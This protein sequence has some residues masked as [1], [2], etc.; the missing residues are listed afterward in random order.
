MA[1]FLTIIFILVLGILALVGFI[2]VGSL[3]SKGSVERALNMTL[4]SITLPR[5][6]ETPQGTQQRPEKELI[7]IMEQLFSSLSN[8]HSKGWNKFVY[9]EPYISFEISV[10]N[11]GEEIIFYAAVPKYFEETFQK[12]VYGIFPLA[13]VV[14]VKDYNIFNSN[15]TS[16][17]AYLK[18][19]ANPI[20]PIKTYQMLEIDP[21]NNILNALSKLSENGEGAAIQIL[22]RPSHQD[23]IKKLAQRVSKEM[24]SGLNFSKALQA[25]KHP[26]KDKKPDDKP[27]PPRI[28]TPFETEIVKGIQSK[29]SKSLFD[30]NLRIIASAEDSMRAQQILDDICGSFVQLSSPD[31]N[32]FKV[33]KSAGRYIEKLLFNFSFRIFNNKESILL[34]SEEITSLYHFPLP[35]TLAPRVRFLRSKSAEPPLELPKEGISIGESIYR[36]EERIIRLP[37][38]DRRRHLYIIGQTGTGKTT[39]MKSL[40]RQDVENGKGICLIDPHGEFA[41]FVLSI[42]PKERVEDV[43]YFDPGDI[44]RPMGLNMLEIDPSH[45][46]QKSMVIDELFTIFDKLYDLKTTGGPMFEKYFKNS[47]YLLLDDYEHEIPT[48]ADISRVLV[49]DKY[50]A[51]K[52]TRETNPLVKQF[53]QMEAEK[54][55]GE[56]KLENM[57]PYI[58]SKITSFVFN[59]FLRPIINQQVSAF[60]IREVMDNG[61]ILVVN[62]SKGKLGALNADLLGMVVVNKILMA[63]LSRVD[64]QDEKS[65]KDFYLYIDEFHNVTTDSIGIILSEA[66]KYHLDLIIAHQFIKQLKESTR[67]AVFG[68]VGSIV[69]FRVGPDDAEYMKNRFEP[70]FTAR[71]LMNIDNLHAYVSL[72]INNK[73]VRPFN[74][75]LETDKVFGAGSKELAD[76]INQMSKL[77]FG[78]PREEVDTEIKQRFDK[79]YIADSPIEEYKST[80]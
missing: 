29:A 57:A 77:K 69:T 39:I 17:G 66:R 5:D 35:T 42:I 48:L 49:D 4:F 28:I 19:S 64:I 46:E 63:A 71:D 47:V 3:R 38:E 50:R 27:E 52:L 14:H 74:I 80:F 51:D 10:H 61:K 33:S 21:L 22:I 53:W 55:G 76:V 13:E 26:K 12:Q 30:V 75:K 9:G 6:V 20:L 56:Q 45:P 7:S 34:S 58:S 78:R 23:K 37:D 54:A 16:I 36:G 79:N 18:L 65:R 72:I 24:Q 68:N 2:L 43:I 15:G 32:G 40:L 31:M 1:I 8:I 73:T 41:E 11:A 44:S 67:D 62:L 25:I 59:E 70:V 60:N